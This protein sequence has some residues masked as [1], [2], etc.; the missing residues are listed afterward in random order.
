MHKNVL[1]FVSQQL[2]KEM[3]MW[4]QCVLLSFPPYCTA[5]LRTAK[6]CVWGGGGWKE[7][8]EEKQ[9]EGGTESQAAE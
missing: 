4:F 9:G 6:N 5:Y 2:V 1:S 8:L 7:E 3:V